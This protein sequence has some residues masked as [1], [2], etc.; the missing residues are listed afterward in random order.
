MVYADGTGIYAN[1]VANEGANALAI[2]FF[3]RDTKFARSFWTGRDLCLYHPADNTLI[4][5]R[6]TCSRPSM[7][8]LL[9]YT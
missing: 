7:P 5:G 2:T 3:T 6:N 4:A 8:G 1:A 9:L